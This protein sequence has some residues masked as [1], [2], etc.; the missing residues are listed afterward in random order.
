MID[1]QPVRNLPSPGLMVLVVVDGALALGCCDE[2]G[3]WDV[4]PY[5]KAWYMTEHDVTHWAYVRQW[6]IEVVDERSH[7]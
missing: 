6:R 2:T 1:W 4:Q 7:T 3:R 5:K